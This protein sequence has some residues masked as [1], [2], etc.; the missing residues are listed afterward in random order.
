MLSGRSQ[1][2]LDAAVA[3]LGDAAVAAVG[4]NADPETADRLVD[5]ATRH[6]GPRSTAR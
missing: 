3:E 4:D 1:E 6:V 2:T 5:A